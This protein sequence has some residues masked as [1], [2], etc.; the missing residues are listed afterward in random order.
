MMMAP[1]MGAVWPDQAQAGID[2]Q[3]L[4]M[5]TD[6]TL[7]QFNQLDAGTQTAVTNVRRRRRSP[8]T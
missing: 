4:A 1:P 7:V 2:P 6:V 8:R 3:F 5:V